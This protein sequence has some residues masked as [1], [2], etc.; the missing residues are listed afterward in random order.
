M[1]HL[2]VERRFLASHALTLG[3]VVEDV[4]EHDWRVRVRVSRPQLDDDGL[5]MDFHELERILEGV[6][7]PLRGK[8]L[9]DV[10]MFAGRNASAEHVA[11]WLHAGIAD[12]L[13]P[14][15]R[16]TELS[17]CEAPDCWAVITSDD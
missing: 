17:V 6:I 15:I 13:P 3:G 5:V 10:P 9:N 16:L 2:E 12:Q 1:Y 8:N 11:A 7:A 4:H 14:E